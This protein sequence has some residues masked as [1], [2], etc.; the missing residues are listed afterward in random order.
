MH[1]A[2]HSFSHALAPSHWPR[3]ARRLALVALILLGL[4]AV[5][6][7]VLDPLAT[8]Y[9]RKS[10]SELENARGDF[11]RV[12]VT[13]FPPGY[14][15]TH[16]KMIEHPGGRWDAPLFYAEAVRVGLDWRRL[17]GGVLEARARLVE[18]KIIVLAHAPKQKE[19]AKKAVRK[20]PD[21]SAFLRRV[22]PLR[23]GRVEIVRG[24]L[25]FR[26]P[27]Q[28]REPELW[29]HRLELAAENLATRRKLAKGRPTT[30]SARGVVGRSGDLT[31]FVTADPLAHPLAFAGRFEMVGLR[32]AELYDFIEPKTKLQTPKGT[33]D[34]F[35]EFT[36]QGG[37]FE[38]GVK[39]VLKNVE[40]RAS[41]PGAWE[42]FKAWVADKSV[43]VAQNDNPGRKDIST[44]VPVRGRLESPDV[45]L[46]PAV[47]G[48][49]RNA[50]VEGL[51]SGFAHLP[52]PEAGHKQGALEQ[53]K[54][55]LTKGKGPPK[56]QPEAEAAG[57]AGGTGKAA[58]RLTTSPAGLL[59]EGAARKLQ[60]ALARAGEPVEGKASGELDG[61][62]RA[63]LARFQR[64]HDLPATGDPDE[65]TV[66]RLGLDPA[67]VFVSGR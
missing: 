35:G 53:T 18:P 55:A 21:A 15:I 5:V 28:P 52:P 19:V 46:W 22:V 62:T 25:L 56:A 9:T 43:E 8:H 23:I 27:T 26:D 58:V 47:L 14:T 41:E 57:G 49:V 60:Q 7:L 48:V 16:V 10:L 40:V 31:L 66:R 36:A 11:E 29:V 13:V 51:T 34:V 17:F 61:P 63:A 2:S 32:V 4:A 3:W 6:R 39:P 20:A 24:E 65:A 38:A 42:R 67:E 54:D 1:S 30:I 64:A 45:Q 50:F 12:H 33:V 37:R 44:I 59:R